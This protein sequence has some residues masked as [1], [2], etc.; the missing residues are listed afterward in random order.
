M[1]IRI[2]NFRSVV[3]GKTWRLFFFQSILSATPETRGSIIVAIMT[4]MQN[5]VPQFPRKP[6]ERG[7]QI[8][9]A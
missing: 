3:G 2:T 4:F 7:K 8:L 9:A 1:E 6:R 5:L